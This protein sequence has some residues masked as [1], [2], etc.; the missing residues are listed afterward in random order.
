MASSSEVAVLAIKQLLHARTY[1]NVLTYVQVP[2]DVVE[3]G[4]A[5]LLLL[6][7]TVYDAVSVGIGAFQTDALSYTGGEAASLG[8][9]IGMPVSGPPYTSYRN[10]PHLL[11]TYIPAAPLA[12]GTA[13]DYQ[14]AVV[15]FKVGKSSGVAGK[16]NRGSIHIT[17]VPEA[18]TTGDYV[19]AANVPS[20]Q[21]AINDCYLPT[22][23]IT[24]GS[25]TFHFRPVVY[26]PTKVDRV[27]AIGLSS[28]AG[29]VDVQTMTLNPKLGTMRHR[30]TRLA[31]V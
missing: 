14:P 31:P 9:A 1:V 4:A 20:F 27:R 18:G 22:V 19:L 15:S 8:P 12:G 21:A 25:N 10:P 7:G 26:S 16:S 17:G 6:L 13:G 5:E 2:G 23:T 28:Y 11:A 3:Y 24:S 30:K 29:T